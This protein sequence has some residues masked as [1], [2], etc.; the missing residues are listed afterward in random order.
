[1]DVYR[2]VEDPSG[3]IRQNMTGP[4]CNQSPK[5]SAACAEGILDSLTKERWRMVEH[6]PDDPLILKGLADYIYLYIER[7]REICKYVYLYM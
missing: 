6:T 4:L 5:G 7:E 1:M 2:G 3:R